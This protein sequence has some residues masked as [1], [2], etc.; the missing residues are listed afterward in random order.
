LKFIKKSFTSQVV[1]LV[2]AVVVCVG[3][4]SQWS[5]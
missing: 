1:Q 5:M 2:E 4:K 3:R